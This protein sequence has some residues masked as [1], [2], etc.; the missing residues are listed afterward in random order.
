M[1]GSRNIRS[2][3]LGINFKFFDN[4]P[5]IYSNIH[6]FG[7]VLGAIFFTILIVVF[8]IPYV[9]TMVALFLIQCIIHL[10]GAI[11]NALNGFSIGKFISI[12]VGLLIFLM[13]I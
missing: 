13:F 9:V 3:K 2:P 8:T 1:D 6:D 11:F 12:C 10:I 7:D 4:M 5:N